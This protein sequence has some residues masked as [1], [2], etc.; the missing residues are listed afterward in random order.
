MKKAIATAPN[1]VTQHIDLTAGDISQY[2]VDVIQYAQEE[3]ILKVNEM[4]RLRDE[5]LKNT[6]WTQLVDASVST[7]NMAAYTSYRQALRDIP[8]SYTNI[9][10]VIWPI[11]DL[12]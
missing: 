12:V 3:S 1:Q 9:D 7:D 8:Q 10:D 4:R 6:D 5:K 11:L 2:D